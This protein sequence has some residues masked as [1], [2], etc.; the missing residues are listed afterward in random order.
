[1]DIVR[2][3]PVPGTKTGHVLPGKWPDAP[4]GAA[5]RAPG[6][7]HAPRR[8]PPMD[9]F[10]IC[11]VPGAKNGHVLPGKWPDAPSGAAARAPGSGHAPRRGPPMDIVRLCAVPGRRLGMSSRGSGPTRPAE[12]LHVPPG[13]FMPRAGV[14]R[15]TYSGYAR[16]RARKMGMSS[17]AR[18]LGLNPRRSNENDH[19]RPK[20]AVQVSA[21]SWQPRRTPRP[22]VQAPG[23]RPA[24]HAAAW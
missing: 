9:I 15:W 17:R 14:R 13:Q 21:R 11:A 22:P 6:S 2:L 24:T 18:R 8:G 12:P 19:Q 4:S 3:C 16:S 23:S 1:M 20:L 5:A 10:R 7:G